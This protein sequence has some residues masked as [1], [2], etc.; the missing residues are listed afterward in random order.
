MCFQRKE[1]LLLLFVS[2][3]LSKSVFHLSATIFSNGKCLLVS[4]VALGTE[5]WLLANALSGK[6]LATVEEKERTAI[7]RCV[8]GVSEPQQ[9]L[10]RPR[11]NR[12]AESEDRRG[13][14]CVRSELHSSSD[15]VRR[16]QELALPVR[17]YYTP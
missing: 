16:R 9:H 15:R 2:M 10:R 3:A 8:D 12:P 11:P 5:G 6:R 13:H 14:R 1:Q 7:F 17:E 4:L